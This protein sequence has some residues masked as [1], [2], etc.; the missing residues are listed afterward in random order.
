MKAAL[1]V[2]DLATEKPNYTST[3]LAMAM[4]ARGH[5][6]WYITPGDFAYDPDNQIHAHAM[7]PSNGTLDSAEQFLGQLK[8]EDS[9]KERITVDEL[10]VLWLRND[11]SLDLIDRPWAYNVGIIFGQLAAQRGVLVINDPF[12]LARAMNKLYFQQFPSDVCPRTLVTR[13]P[14]DVKHFIKEHGG[15]GVIKPL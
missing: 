4:V 9:Q 13:S 7:A 3:R 1:F 2:N 12:G 14:K 15:S 6:V 10:D 8:A 5:E 11:P